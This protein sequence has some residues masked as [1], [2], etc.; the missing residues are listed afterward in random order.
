[1][2]HYYGSHSSC[3]LLL[4]TLLLCWPSGRRLGWV[5]QE[6]L[7]QCNLRCLICDRALDYAGLK[8]S[9]C[10]RPVC[11]MGQC[12]TTAA[13]LERRE[14]D[15]DIDD[16]LLGYE[17]FGLGFDLGKELKEK[18]E[19]VDLLISFLSASIALNRLVSAASS[20]LALL[21]PPTFV[22]SSV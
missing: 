22:C 10:A 1:M 15:G 9:V 19:V 16:V 18:P 2:E 5:A 21:P 12:T 7:L 8:P 17:E 13:T 4:L 20:H 3:R 11:I 6:K 14:G